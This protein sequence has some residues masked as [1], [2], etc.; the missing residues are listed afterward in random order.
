VAQ[1]CFDRIKFLSFLNFAEFKFQNF[2]A[3]KNFT[4]R[5]I[6]RQSKILIYEI[7]QRAKLRKF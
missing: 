3:F 4:S 5:K 7:S 6:L 2:V 1:A